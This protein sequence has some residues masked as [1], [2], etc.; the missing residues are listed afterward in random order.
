LTCEGAEDRKRSAD[1]H[2]TAAGGVEYQIR[3]AGPIHGQLMSLGKSLR[4][5][6]DDALNGG[7]L[8]HR[9]ALHAQHDGAGM[10]AYARTQKSRVRPAPD[11]ANV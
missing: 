8:L 5:V 2:V 1:V 3:C 10:A 7:R 6:S 4:C 11:A 9:V